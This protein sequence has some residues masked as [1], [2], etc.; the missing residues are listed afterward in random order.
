MTLT[1]PWLPCTHQT[2]IYE[3]YSKVTEMLEV[4]HIVGKDVVMSLRFSK[5]SKKSIN[6][7]GERTPF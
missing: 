5:K 2:F 4:F 3:T 1:R 7:G 6:K